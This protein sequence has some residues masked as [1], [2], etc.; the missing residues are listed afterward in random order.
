MLSAEFDSD[1]CLFS[2]NNI[3]FY[4]DN[5]IT[6]NVCNAQKGKQE[7]NIAFEML[8]MSYAVSWLTFKWCVLVFVACNTL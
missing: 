8:L 7:K 5:N 3:F 4:S 2:E 6:N 1:H